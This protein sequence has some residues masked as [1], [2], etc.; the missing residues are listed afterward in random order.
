MNSVRRGPLWVLLVMLAIAWFGTLDQRRLINPDEGRYAEIAREMA[1]SGDWV[2]PRLNDLKYFEKPP[3]QYW[4]TAVAFTLF[5]EHHWSARLWSALTGFLGILFTVFAAGRLFGASA[6]IVAGA[7]LASSVL[8]NLIGHINT[9]DAAVSFFLSSAVFAL[10]LA[11]REGIGVVESRRWRDGMWA[12]LALGVLSKGLIG[13][14]L[15][16]A[17]LFAYMIWQRDWGLLARTRPLRGML[18]VLAITAPWFIAVSLAN[19]EFPRFFFIHEHFERFLTKQHGRYEPA[20]YFIPI[21]LV[22]MLPWL[23]SLAQGLA[24]GWRRDGQAFQPARLLLVWSVV[25]FVFFSASGSKLASYILPIFPALATLIAVH[26]ADRFGQRNLHWQTL[27]GL[28]IGL[29]VFVLA[30]WTTR[31]E[32]DRHGIELYAAY[33]LWFHAAGAALFCGALAAFILHRRGRHLLATLLLAS[34]GHAAGQIILLGH[35]HIGTVNSA[36]DAAQAVRDQ[37][38]PGVPFFSVN[39]YDQS[40]PFYLRRTTTLVSYR[41]ELGFGIAQEPHKYIANL[42]DFE[43]A[44]HAAPAAW[45]LLNPETAQALAERDFPMTEVFRD[46]RR[47]I[48]KKTPSP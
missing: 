9:L 6:G 19:P 45:A 43:T 33:Q 25:V 10:C 20:W 5:G 1:V 40:L 27:P 2:T 26:I 32:N 23:G 41:G 21:L 28:L 13:L 47:V 15:P 44:W 35:D 31:L 34:G 11:E 39:T 14:V 22:G 36:H 38:P 30:F 3:L 8:W 7:V 18:I 16:A 17:T 29:A 24:R 12:L 42:A 37:I 4:A 46:A 48:V